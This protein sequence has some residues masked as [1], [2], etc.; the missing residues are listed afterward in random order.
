MTTVLVIEDNREVRENTAELLELAGYKV[1]SAENGKQGVEIATRQL[2]HL[3]ICDIMMPELD[4]YGVLHMLNRNP[5]TAYIPFIF[6]TAKAERSDLRKGMEMGADDYIT[7][8]F[9]DVELMNAIEVRLKKS[10]NARK[11]IA[12][13]KENIDEFLNKAAESEHLKLTDG[14][15]EVQQYRKKQMIYTRSHRPGFLF[16]VLKGKIKTFRMNDDGKE[17]ITGIYKEHDFFGYTP[18]LKEMNY[19]DNAEVMEDAEIMLIPQKDFLS[20]LSANTAIARQFIKLLSANLSEK[21]EQLIQLAYNSLRKRVA[22]SLLLVH[23]RFRKNDKD[24]PKLAISREDLAQIV[25]TATESLIRTL[26]DFKAEKLIEIND[27]KILISNEQK[28]RG[29]LN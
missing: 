4:G 11:E 19:E 23:D 10:E 2:P 15:R 5:A 16:Y 9:D 12:H 17:L 28:L 18:I 21:E 29:M 20:V 14:E 7:K 1:L 22:D 3:I 13:G 24:N 25:G 26:S 6:L 8:P 27:G